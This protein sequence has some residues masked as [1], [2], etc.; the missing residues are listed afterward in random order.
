VVDG[1]SGV[2]G[3][4]IHNT[5]RQRAADEL[6]AAQAAIAA[7]RARLAEEIHNALAQGLAMIVMQLADAEAKL[8]PAWAR[9]EKP[10]GM[11]RELAVQ[12]LAYAR[13]SVTMLQPSA[14]AAG[15]TRAIREEIDRLGRRFG[16]TLKFVVT[17][18][19]VLLPASVESALAEISREALHNAAHHS[20]AS[21]VDVELA[22]EEGTVRLAIADDGIGFD[23]EH[24]RANAGGLTGMQ[25]RAAR[26]GVALTFVTEPG[27]GTEVVASWS[28]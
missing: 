24:V 3:T 22:F 8:G 21:R 11:V 26:A 5:E 19:A 23:A 18:S 12:G 25:D 7:E 15:L 16:A 20:R 6:G 27:A 28:Q 9:A 4:L 10:L 1:K 17:G 13:R 2:L 14:S